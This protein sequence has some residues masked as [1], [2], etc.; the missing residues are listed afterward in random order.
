M[1]DSRFRTVKA[2][3][4]RAADLDPAARAAYLTAACN[5]DPDLRSEVE[6]L[7]AHENST[8]A[9]LRKDHLRA[10]LVEAA[11]HVLA[12]GDD[13]SPPVRI[14]P[15]EIERELGRGGMGIVYLARQTT[16][17]RRA[18]ALKILRSVAD[19]PRFRARFKRERKVLALLRHPGIARILAVG[20]DRVGRPYYV[21]EFVAGV[22]ITDFCRRRGLGLTQR[23]QLLARVARAVDYAHRNRVIHRD[24]KPTNILVAARTGRFSPRIIDFGIARLIGSR[25]RDSFTVT[26]DGDCLGTVQYMSPEQVL[27][28]VADIDARADIYALGAILFELVAERPLVPDEL[29]SPMEQIRAI[30]ETPA[31]ALNDFLPARVGI[32]VA[33]ERLLHGCLAKEPRRRIGSAGVLARELKRLATDGGAE[34]AISRFR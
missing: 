9:V 26:R 25:D 6:T 3:V 19:N 33:L 5:G 12:P 21:M 1:T 30:C 8:P 17:V 29:Q 14:G 34:M 15:Y 2:I 13:R 23:L 31:P 4:L 22:P 32:G 10:R 28:R 18:V 11:D 16:P 24:L 20:A 7:L 27:G